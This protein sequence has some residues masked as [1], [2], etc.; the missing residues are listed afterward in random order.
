MQTILKQPAPT[1]APRARN[2]NT[3]LAAAIDDQ[4]AQTLAAKAAA[5]A[6]SRCGVQP[7]PTISTTPDDIK[8]LQKQI[9]RLRGK[10]PALGLMHDTYDAAFADPACMWTMHPGCANWPSMN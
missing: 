3:A 7:A 10:M 4:R 8:R 1:I 6:G 5:L 2:L 9:A